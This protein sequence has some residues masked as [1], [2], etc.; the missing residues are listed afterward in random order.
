MSEQTI[1]KQAD[2]KFC[3]SCGAVVKIAAEICPKC[4]V[5][6]NAKKGF[7]ETKN[8][9]ERKTDWRVLFHLSF[10]LGFLGIDRFYAGKTGSGILK[11]ITMGG[12]GIWWIMDIINVANGNYTDATGKLV[13]KQGAKASKHFGI[14]AGILIAWTIIFNGVIIPNSIK[15]VSQHSST[16]SQPAKNA[17]APVAELSVWQLSNEYQ[18]NEI[19]ADKA[20]KNKLIKISGIVQNIAKDIN[21]NPNVVI[22]DDD[23]LVRIHFK[24]NN[25]LGNLVKGQEIAVIGECK[26]MQVMTLNALTLKVIIIEKA[27]FEE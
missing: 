14:S 2:E 16:I 20:Y 23:N 13:D 5:R 11:L 3:S 24:D 22:G 26:G 25:K 15:S 17:K 27:F 18:N 7:F 19:A 10:W 4:G 9:I 21:G 8:D 12:C 6:Q 1:T